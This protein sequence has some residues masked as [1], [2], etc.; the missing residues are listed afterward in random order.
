MAKGKYQEWLT[1]EKLTLLEGWARDGLTDAQIAHNIGIRRPTLYDWKKN[2][3]DISDALKKGKEVVDREVENSLLK[4]AVGMK[5]KST[6]YKMVKVDEDVLKVKRAR[7]LNAYKLDHPEMSKQEL[8]MAAVENVKTYE[9][10]PMMINETELAPDTSAAIFWLKNRKPEQYRDHSFQELNN[11]QA[12]KAKTDAEISKLKLKALSG[13]GSSQI[14]TVD[15]LLNLITE[16]GEENGVETG[17]AKTNGETNKKASDEALGGLK[18]VTNHNKLSRLFTPK[19]MQ[20]IHEELNNHKW[21]LMINYGA[22]RAGKTFVDNFVFLLEVRRA[23]MIAKKNGVEHPLYI[24]AGV[25]SKTIYNNILI[26]LANTFGLVFKFDKHN[27]FEVTFSNLPPVK[28]VQ[29]FTGSISGLGAI[30][31]MTS[32]GA[33]INE[34]SMANEE[35]FN[36]IRQRCSAEGARVVCDTNPD[37][38]THW[39]KENY[40]DNPN[41]SDAIVSNHFVLDD[42][43]HLD[44]DYVKSLKESTPSGMFYDRAI[45]GLWVSGEGMVYRDFDRDKHIIDR[46]QLP[47]GLF[48]YAGIDWGYDH[49][50]VIVVVGQDSKGNRYLVEEHTARFEE[51]DYW[52]DV[53]KDIIKRYGNIDFYADSARPEHVARFKREHIRCYN[54]YKSVLTGIE[55]VAKGFKTGTLFIVKQAIDKFL[56]EIYQYIWDETKDAPVKANDDVMDALRYAIATFIRLHDQPKRTSRRKQAGVLKGMGLV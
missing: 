52:V 31:G 30:R 28:V 23:A 15:H 55:Y 32:T 21:K 6:T 41:H 5:T 13:V 42:N 33:Y 7:F 45:L 43:T 20:V 49:N 44:R 16:T 4:R 3:P 9:Q 46:S 40:I 39:L 51:I 14:N 17:Q 34:A 38:P 26:E 25:S 37:V 8:M 19:Q 18:I 10:I 36:E 1:P 48:Y 24:L 29:A 27:S 22:V 50:G 11:A 56:D 47:D 2:H 35:V 53:A 54:G 12:D